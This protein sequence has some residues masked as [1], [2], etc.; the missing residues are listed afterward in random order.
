MKVLKNIIQESG[1]YYRDIKGKLERQILVLPK[2][3]IKMRKIAGHPY[4]Y[5]QY[6]D[7]QKVIHKYLGKEPPEELIQQIKKR[8][9]SQEELK[10][11]KEAL[12]IIQRSKGRRRDKSR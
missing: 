5:H 12:K 9:S 2:G 7:G 10:K 3:S 6:R 1:Q 8:K 11:V 4:Y